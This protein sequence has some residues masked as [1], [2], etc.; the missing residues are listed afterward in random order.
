MLHFIRESIQ[1][2]I[3]W[4][5]VILLIVP[6][7]LWG[8]NSYFGNGGSLVI[9]SVNGEEISRQAYTQEYYQQRN[10]LQQMLGAQY[11]PSMFDKRIKSQALDDL[12]KKEI[13]LQNAQSMGFRVGA[14]N[15]ISSIQSF[16]AF[17]DNG[18]FSNELY[19]S[20]LTAQ[21]ESPAGFEQRI[22]RAILSQQLYAGITTT[23]VM[24][25]QEI[26]TILQLQE[27]KRNIDHF[28]LAKLDF[29]NTEDAS[30]D[31]ILAYYNGH[32]K[33][34]M[35][36]EKVSVEY[37]EL[38]ADNLSV[39]E[40]PSEEELKQYYQDRN[41]QFKEKEQRRTRHILIEIEKD[42]K[43]ELIQAALQK[44][45]DIKA[46]ID[47]GEDFEALAKKYSHD[48][49]SAE[50]GGDLGYFGAGLLD[51][52]YDKA[53]FALQ[54]GEVS[55]PTLTAFGYHIIKLE[56][57]KG[58][59]NQSFESVREEL[60]QEYKKSAKEK[61]YFAEVEKLTN[62]AYEVPDTLDDAAGAIGAEIKTTDLF[63]RNRGTG[64]AT[65]P[66]I[67]AAAFGDDVLNNHY[68]SEPIEISE[69]RVVVIRIKEH[70]E[71]SQR[72]LEEVKAE[73]MVS[74]LDKKSRERAKE[75]GEKLLGNLISSKDAD[76]DVQD[77]QKEWIKSGE[78]TR[79]ETKID[80]AI[81]NKAFR[82]SASSEGKAVFGG[83][84]LPSGDYVIIR[85]TSVNTPEVASIPVEKRQSL[86]KELAGIV[87][88]ADFANMLSS[89]KETSRIII[90]E[91]N[92]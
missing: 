92:L 62:L 78:I 87:G 59:V 88:D 4:A 24:T 41:E 64:I 53:M 29:K 70:Q 60:I 11:D 55:E 25:K 67:R 80:K 66:K 36:V 50:K 72:P 76:K 44:A 19:K 63:E 32:L 30:E 16:E 49:G 73:I 27:Q 69:N 54:E 7:A 71:P 89:L 8:I 34:Y 39:D 20:Q 46:R 91:D 22:Q 68:N 43:E 56:K 5:I 51:P 79:S 85:L 14:Q 18:Q 52:N 81:V 75:A 35:T 40:M 9:A 23:A 33:Q 13:L 37:I 77:M 10:R 47:K 90:Q 61:K 2:W 58:G 83:L 1:G 28:L 17:Q 26:D 38:L 57:I 65:N 48:P 84:A 42:A 12:V 74:I 21:G 82:L 15:V 45:K 31:A 3:A 86:S 6:F